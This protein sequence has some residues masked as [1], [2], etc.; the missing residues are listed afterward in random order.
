MNSRAVAGQSRRIY[1]RDSLP[2]VFWRQH[3]GGGSLEQINGQAVPST[4]IG[5]GRC[6][7]KTVAP[8]LCYLTSLSS[9]P[10]TLPRNTMNSNMFLTRNKTV[11]SSNTQGYK[12]PGIS[13]KREREVCTSLPARPAARGVCLARRNHTYCCPQVPA[14]LQSL[15]QAAYPFSCQR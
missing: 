5:M 3:G 8:G 13:G 15:Q 14:T 1:R 9:H 12:I 4:K 7:Q 11:L 6:I 2:R 10:T